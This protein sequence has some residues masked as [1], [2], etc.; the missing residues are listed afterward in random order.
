MQPKLSRRAFIK[1][2]VAA[3][4]TAA[5]SAAVPAQAM[6]ADPKLQLATL[7][8][9][10]KCVG[11]GACVE[12]CTETNGTKYP[13]PEKPFPKMIPPRVPVE[14]W[15]ERQDETGRLTP[16]NW[17]YIQQA[18]VDVNGEETELNIPRRCMH[19]VN[20]PCVKLCPWGAARQYPNGISRIDSDICLGGSK[21][22]SVFGSKYWPNFYSLCWAKPFSQSFPNW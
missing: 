20:P 14:D 17:V 9:I 7:L 21:C 2:S 6:P 10:R 1:G 8:D 22:R 11:C 19:C 12:A 13:Q 18:T 5:A 15:S 16:Y 3:A 4:C